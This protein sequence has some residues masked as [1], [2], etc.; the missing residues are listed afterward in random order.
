M[1]LALLILSV[2][3]FCWAVFQSADLPDPPADNSDELKQTPTKV[4][5][6]FLDFTYNETDEDRPTVVATKKNH[7]SKTSSSI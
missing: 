3:L 5:V 4:T 1:I 7:D 6:E 2:G